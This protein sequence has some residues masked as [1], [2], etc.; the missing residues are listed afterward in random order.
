MSAA[1]GKAYEALQDEEQ[2]AFCK[3]IAEEAKKQLETRVRAVC[4]R[5][6]TCVCLCVCVCLGGGGLADVK[7]ANS[8]QQMEQEALFVSCTCGRRK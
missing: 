4:V 5:A 7:D 1:V 6:C 3:D 2:V 8:S